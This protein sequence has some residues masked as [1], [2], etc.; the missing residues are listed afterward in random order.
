MRL[1]LFVIWSLSKNLFELTQLDERLI[2]AQEEMTIL[3]QQNNQLQAQAEDLNS[4]DFKEAAIRN[5]LGL[6]KPGETVV[7]LPLGELEDATSSST[8]IN[9]TSVDSLAVWQ[10][11]LVLFL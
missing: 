3:K 7:I 6:S 5:K 9:P 1:F 2:R 10:R 4:H 8:G 11:W